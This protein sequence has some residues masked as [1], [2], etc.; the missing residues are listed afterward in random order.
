MNM[1]FGGEKFILSSSSDKFH[2]EAMI[3][4]IITI[5]FYLSRLIIKSY[6]TPYENESLEARTLAIKYLS[7]LK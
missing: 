3:P 2:I 1:C 7:T 4:I 6:V 5:Y